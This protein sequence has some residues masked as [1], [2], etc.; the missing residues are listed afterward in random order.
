MNVIQ[1]FILILFSLILF[2][3]FMCFIYMDL[4]WLQ[5]AFAILVIGASTGK[6]GWGKVYAE[7][8]LFFPFV[9]TMMLVYFGLGILGFPSANDFTHPSAVTYWLS[10]GALRSII[11]ANTMF[12][13]SYLL[14]F[15]TLQ[16]IIGLPMPIQYKKVLILGRALFLSITGSLTE[17]E[18]H[19][20]LIPDYQF[21]RL[22]L[23]LWFR[24]KLQLSMSI[25]ILLIRDSH[26]QGEMIDNRIKHCF[27]K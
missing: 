26:Y 5:L 6:F 12:F 3:V 23:K 22:P 16:D 9:L 14:A 17:L 7:L 11:F 24:L 2:I 13:V 4:W 20:R 8:K 21:R 18:L 27:T 10:Y 1:K 25:I 19:L 15:I